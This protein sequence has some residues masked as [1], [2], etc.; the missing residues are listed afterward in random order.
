MLEQ[1]LDHR[2]G[3]GVHIGIALGAIEV[4]A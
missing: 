1:A 3:G 2:Q 4:P